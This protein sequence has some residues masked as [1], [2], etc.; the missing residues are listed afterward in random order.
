MCYYVDQMATRAEVK[1]IFNVGIDNADQFYQGSFVSGFDHPNLPII[2]NDNLTKITTHS[3]WGLMPSWAKLE[4][5]SFR[6][7]KLNARIDEID[8]TPSYQNITSNRCLIIS[9][10]FYEWRWLDDKGKEKEKYHI[11][12][13]TDKIFCFAGLFDSW[14]NPTT[15]EIVNSYTMV[16]TEANEI[17]SYVHNHKKRMPIMLKRKDELSWLDK[18]VEISEFAYPNYD[19]NLKATPLN[20]SEQYELF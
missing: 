18:S 2:T 17:M 20:T 14:A 8:S 15:G 9:T 12:S 19:A 10:G 4:Q 6:N 5:M 11:V 1:E 3:T 7:G 13:Q 16:T